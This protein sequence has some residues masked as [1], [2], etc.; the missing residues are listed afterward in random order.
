MDSNSYEW[1]KRYA[2]ENVGGFISGSVSIA[3]GHPFD[4]IKVRQQAGHTAYRG[5]LD[6]ARETIRNEGI[7]ALWKGMMSPLVTNSSM[8]AITFSSWQ[9]AQRLLHFEENVHAP[10]SKVFAAGSI[11]GLVQCSLA[12]PMELVRIKLQVQQEGH[13]TYKGNFDCIQQVVRAEG[14]AGLYRGNVSMMLR[15]GPAFGVYFSVYEG[16]KRWL[17]PDL[18][19][20]DKEPMWLEAA[21][22][23]TTGAVTWTAVMPMDNI[24][25]RIQSLPEELAKDPEQRKLRRVARDIYAEGGLRAFYRGL[26]AAILRGVALNAIVSLGLDG[27]MG[28][29]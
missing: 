24:S 8:N 12:T 20:N 4:T 25:T 26:P 14:L 11:A 13:R 27:W 6:C 28:R 2:A 17:A 18:K 7:R 21:G 29:Q 23:A 10:L 3:V 16:T 5:A 9:E 1:L 15:E 22:G 19:P